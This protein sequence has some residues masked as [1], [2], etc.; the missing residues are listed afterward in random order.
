[1]R[2]NS[3]CAVALLFCVVL[4][5]TFGALFFVLRDDDRVAVEAV[6][7]QAEVQKEY[8]RAEQIEE[9]YTGM[10]DLVDAEGDDYVKRRLIDL[11]WFQTAQ[12][13]EMIRD[14]SYYIQHGQS[15][16]DAEAQGYNMLIGPIVAVVL[17][18]AIISG[19]VQTGPAAWR[20]LKDRAPDLARDEQVAQQEARLETFK[21]TREKSERPDAL[22]ID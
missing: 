15:R 13:W 3:G 17:A 19:L 18:A 5:A 9:T 7:A 10:V 1:M 22:D 11:L 4:V 16:Q 12:Q 14:Q 2:K 21:S 20:W 8:A 6:R